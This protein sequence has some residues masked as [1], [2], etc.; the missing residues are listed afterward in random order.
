LR[1]FS[2]PSEKNPIQRP[3]GEKNGL[4]APSVPESASALSSFSRRA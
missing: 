4:D 2:F 1:F 3:S